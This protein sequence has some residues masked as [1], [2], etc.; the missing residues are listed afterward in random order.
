MSENPARVVSFH[1]TVRDD[2][3]E[4][5]DSSRGG[6]PMSVLLGAGNLIEGVDAALGE[7]AVGESRT[8][9]VPPELGYGLHDE[10]LLQRLPRKHFDRV[11]NLAAGMQLMANGPK[12]QQ[13]VTVI[14]V[15]M[16]V[17]DVD[18]NH[19]LAGKALGFDLEL[20]ASRDATAEE[21]AHGHAHGPGGHAHD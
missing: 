14:K 6:E 12:G 20:T 2:G 7:M 8:I 19:P 5:V 21:I 15:G 18:L 16:S 1:Y 9:E 10:T 4:V 13:V 17:V 3:G 11:P